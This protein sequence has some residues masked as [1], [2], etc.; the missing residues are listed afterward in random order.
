MREFPSIVGALFT[1]PKNESVFVDTAEHI[2]AKEVTD[3]SAHLI[4][5]DVFSW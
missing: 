5:I 3:T 1:K 2:T 4:G